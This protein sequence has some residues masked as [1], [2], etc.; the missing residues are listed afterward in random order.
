MATPYLGKLAAFQP[1]E[2]TISVYLERTYI[3]F[4]ANK[5]ITD[6]HKVTVF[7]NAIGP[8]TYML[9]RDLMSPMA[10]TDKKYPELC[11][12]LKAHFEAKPIIIAEIPFS[13]KEP[14]TQ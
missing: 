12:T 2:E 9:L 6:K 7:L 8:R 1:K 10:L 3:F 13:P 14:R 4:E 5:I 11:A